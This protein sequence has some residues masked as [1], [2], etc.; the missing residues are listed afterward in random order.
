MSAMVR[1]PPTTRLE[2]GHDKNAALGS[3]KVTRAVLLEKRRKY[4]A[5]VAPP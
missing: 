1:D 2:S 3:I 5:A 4:F